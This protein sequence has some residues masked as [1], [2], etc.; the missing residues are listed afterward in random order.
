M[1]HSWHRRYPHPPARV[2]RA[3]TDPALLAQWLGDGAVV[4]ER[5]EPSRV[6]YR[7]SGGD[8][9]VVTVDG[10]E[11]GARICVQMESEAIGIEVMPRLEAM[12]GD[13]AG[14]A[15][16]VT[17]GRSEYGDQRRETR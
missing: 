2:W 11:Q 1:T 16:A 6:V 13:P 8:L 3:L 5:D 12:I 14:H 17:K 7:V 9:A 15:W 10:D 4:V